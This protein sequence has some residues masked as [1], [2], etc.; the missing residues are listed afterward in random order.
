[1]R[2]GWFRQH[3]NTHRS[4]TN[5]RTAI[6]YYKQHFQ[7][8]GWILILF[9]YCVF[10]RRETPLMAQQLDKRTAVRYYKQRFQKTGWIL[11]LLSLC[12]SWT[13]NGDDSHSPK[14]SNLH[15]TRHL[16]HIRKA[17]DS[18]VCIET[19]SDPKDLTQLVSSKSRIKLLSW[20]SYRKVW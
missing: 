20:L 2:P 18:G 6:K 5:E 7:K 15:F 11:T 4:L 9:F 8:M 3:R 19:E 10:G 1:M 14:Q 12:L 16:R 17:S 13:N